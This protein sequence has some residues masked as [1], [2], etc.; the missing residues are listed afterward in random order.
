MADYNGCLFSYF[1]FPFRRV[2]VSCFELLQILQEHRLFSLPDKQ[3]PAEQIKT[4]T[5]S[6]KG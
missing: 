1:F 5:F 2:H 3:I 6:T 4:K